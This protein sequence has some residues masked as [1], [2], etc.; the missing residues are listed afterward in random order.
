MG[1]ALRRALAIHSRRSPNNELG[2]YIQDSFDPARSLHFDLGLRYDLETQ[3]EGLHRDTNN[4]GP[5]FGFAME[6]I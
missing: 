1:E 2:L 6:P 5:R 3:G 4:F